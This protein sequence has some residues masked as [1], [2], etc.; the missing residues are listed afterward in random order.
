[1]KNQ[2]I[3]DHKNDI[4]WVFWDIHTGEEDIHHGDIVRNS[5]DELITDKP[6]TINEL[7]K[8]YK[9][10]KETWDLFWNN[11]YA[12]TNLPIINT[13]TVKTSTVNVI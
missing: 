3:I 7:A 9:K 4:D 10:G 6:E 5:I 1:M 12:L 13:S 11:I 2:Y 8:G